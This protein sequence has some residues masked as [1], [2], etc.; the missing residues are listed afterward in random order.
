M[1]E[2]I[3]IAIVGTGDWGANL[4]RNF[5]NRDR[6]KVTWVVDPSP[7]RQSLVR[8]RYPDIRLSADAPPSRS[9]GIIP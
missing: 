1:S 5:D 3:G 2:T 9:T 7:A 4:V 8:S 6:S